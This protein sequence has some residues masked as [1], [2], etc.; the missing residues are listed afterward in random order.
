MKPADAPGAG[1]WAA[2]RLE[3]R[4]VDWLVVGV[5]L[6]LSLPALVHAGLVG[7][8]PVAI[9]LATLPFGTVPLRWRRS[10]PGPVLASLAGHQHDRVRHIAGAGAL[11][12]LLLAFAIMLVTGEARAL[13]HLTG[14]AFGSGVAWVVGDRA[15]T[16]HAYLAQL[17]ERAAR[18]ERERED[19][20]RRAAEAERNRI[21]RELHDVVAHNVSVIAVQAGAARIASRDRPGQVIETLGLIERTARS[22]LAEVRTVLGILRKADQEAPGGDRGTPDADEAPAEARLP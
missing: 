8:K 4:Q 16:R 17:E 3:P 6:A 20:A 7:D 1:L 2:G 5:V 13:G 12:A 10:H 18:L 15:R 21:A 22:T 19:H 14:M 11:G 9:G